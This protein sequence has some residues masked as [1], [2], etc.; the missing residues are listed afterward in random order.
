MRL[1]RMA[2]LAAVASGCLVAP[3]ALQAGTLPDISGTWWAQGDSAKRCSISQSGN[4]VTFRNES[5][6]TGNGRFLNPSL[7]QVDWGYSGGRALRGTISPNLERIDW[8]NGTYWARASGA[9]PAPTPNPYRQLTFATATASRAPG[10]I[11]VVDGWGAVERNAKRA[12]V[13]VSFKN[14]G[15]VDATRVVF[16]FP[17]LDR[18]DDV[19]ETLRLDRRGTFSP[20][21]D[22]RGWDSLSS[23]QGGVGHRGYND[24]C[25]TLDLGVAAL[26]LKNAHAATYRVE[27]VEFSNGTIW[28]ETPAGR[29]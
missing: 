10:P 15:R 19:V 7:V 20:G 18:R 16:A 26:S 17:L 13:C 22:I 28:P 11:A 14:E 2:F 23:W 29:R 5:G 9:G 21:I 3:A 25:A 1:V 4:S 12:V 24:N 27:R 6:D 8:S